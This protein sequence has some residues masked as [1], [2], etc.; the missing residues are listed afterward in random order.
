MTDNGTFVNGTERVIV[1][2]LHR[3]QACSLITI[4][5]PFFSGKVRYSARVVHT[6]VPSWT[7]SLTPKTTCSCPYLTVAVQITGV[8]HLRALEFFTEIQYLL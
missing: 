5:V 7:L 3:S 4:K 8:D 1:S 6:V 2:Q